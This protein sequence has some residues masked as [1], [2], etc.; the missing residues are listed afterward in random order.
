MGHERGLRAAVRRASVEDLL[1]E[2]KITSPAGDQILQLES[3]LLQ[4]RDH[5]MKY[6][7]A[8]RRRVS[9]PLA[10]ACALCPPA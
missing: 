8:A 2:D 6:K 7:R 9:W 4:I 1:T 5:E 10:S 3:E